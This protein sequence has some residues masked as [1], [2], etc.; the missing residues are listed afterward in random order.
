MNANGFLVQLKNAY[1]AMDVLA[2]VPNAK[3]LITNDDRVTVDGLRGTV[4]IT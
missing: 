3:D 2:G 4:T 1:A